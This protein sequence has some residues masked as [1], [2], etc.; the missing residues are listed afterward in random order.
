MKPFIVAGSPPPY[1]QVTSVN[2]STSLIPMGAVHTTTVPKWEFGEFPVQVT[3]PN[4]QQS[5]TSIIDKANGSCTY[6]G[7]CVL[8]ICW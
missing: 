7:V 2:N 3:C 1:D 8:C 6:A 5:V 4:C